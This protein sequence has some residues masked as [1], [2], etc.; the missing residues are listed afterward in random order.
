[1]F[2]Q[3]AAAKLIERTI[4]FCISNGGGFISS[5]NMKS[6]N[7]LDLARTISNNIEII[8]ARPGEKIDEDLINL[9]ESEDTHLYGDFIVIKKDKNLSINKLNK[10]YSS[11]NAEKMTEEEIRDLIWPK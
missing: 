9:Q 7:M 5:F 1:M 4:N 11:K 10:N 8:G 2:S 6:V 3:E